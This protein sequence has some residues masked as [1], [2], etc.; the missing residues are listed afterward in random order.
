MR[1]CKKAKQCSSLS[2]GFRMDGTPRSVRFCA[3]PLPVG[4]G[5]FGEGVFFEHS[6]GDNHSFPVGL[7]NSPQTSLL[8]LTKFVEQLEVRRRTW[9]KVS[10][11]ELLISR[12]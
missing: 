12:V 3:V 1:S 2:E 9:L 4:R 8:N 7:G 5:R 10:L 6:N 11:S